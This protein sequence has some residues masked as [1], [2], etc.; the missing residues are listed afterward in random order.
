MSSTQSDWEK[1]LKGKKFVE[2]GTESADANVY[3]TL[4]PSTNPSIYI[5]THVLTDIYIP[6]LAPAESRRQKWRY[7]DHAVHCRTVR[8]PFYLVGCLVS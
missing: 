8:L 6:I 1:L 2:A 4:L 5:L 3:I 7:D